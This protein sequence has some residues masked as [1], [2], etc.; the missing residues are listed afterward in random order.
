MPS[1]NDN[2]D[3]EG[4]K[5]ILTEPE[6]KMLRGEDIGDL[7]DAARYKRYSRIRERLCWAIY[8]FGLLWENWQRLNLDKVFQENE[9][10]LPKM[11]HGVRGMFY[12]L[13]RGLFDDYMPPFKSYLQDGVALAEQDMNNRNVRVAFTVNREVGGNVIVDGAL[14]RVKPESVDSLTIPEMRAVLQKLAESDADVAELVWDELD[15][16]PL[17]GRDRD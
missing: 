12:V 7:T 11:R 8:D 16:E 10:D 15:G 2:P 13:Y 9:I 6:R 5:A 4:P 1:D 17:F 3:V 14:S